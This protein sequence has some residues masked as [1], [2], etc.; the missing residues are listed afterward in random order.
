[1]HSVHHS[2]PH[3]RHNTY[4]LWLLTKPVRGDE[5]SLYVEN[6][7]KARCQSRTPIDAG[8]TLPYPS[9]PHWNRL[10]SDKSYSKSNQLKIDPD[11][12]DE[13]QVFMAMRAYVT[14]LNS[15]VVS[16]ALACKAL[17]AEVVGPDDFQALLDDMI[18]EDI[19]DL[20]YTAY[21]ARR[22]YSKAKKTRKLNSGSCD[23]IATAQDPAPKTIVE[24]LM[25]DGADEWVE[26]I[27]KEFNGLC[28]QGVF[29]HDW[30][31]AKLKKAGITGKPVP[32]S[33]ALVT[34]K[35]KDGVLEKWKT[36]ICIAGHRG[37]VT[38][39]IHYHEVFSPSPVQHTERLLQAMRAK[40][41]LHNLTW[42][43]KMAYTWAPLPAGER[44][45]VVY[46]DGF[47]RYDSQGDE[48][49]AVL[50]HYLY[51]MPS[52]GRGWGKH[53]DEFILS[54][55]NKTGW[56]CRR[57][58]MDPCLFVIDRDTSVEDPDS[59]PHAENPELTHVRE[60]GHLAPMESGLPDCIPSHI[61]RS[62][63]LIHTDDCDAYGE[64]MSILHDI[65]NIMNDKWTTEIIDA[66]FVLGVKRELSIDDEGLWSVKMSMSAFISDLYDV[67][68][69]DITSTLGRKI[70]KIPFPEGYILTKSDIPH[71]G[72]VKS[73]LLKQYQR[74]I[75]SL[76][77]YVRHISPIAAYGCSQLCKLMS[78]PT[79]RAYEAALHMLVYLYTHRDEGIVFHE[80]DSEPIAFVDASNKDD[81]TDGKTQYGYTIMWGGPLI[82]CKSSKL[83]H[84]GINSTYNEYMA[85]HHVIKQ[86]VW[87]R[88]LFHE[89]G[90]ANF[91]S[92]PTLVHA[93][94]KQA[95]S[96]CSEDL[97]TQGNMYFRTGYHY[98]K[99]AV[100]DLY[101]TIQYIDTALNISDAMTKALG[102]NKIKTFL[103]TLHGL[104][105]IP[106]S[107][108]T[109][110]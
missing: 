95:N 64:D 91:I 74:L 14:Q 69:D 41:H 90:L 58:L 23:T 36:R 106:D 65:N 103:D 37:N 73:T 1:M 86:I 82:L 35:Y 101:V 93:D 62:W 78:C 97:V 72:E 29:S 80:T 66:S 22:Y 60:R 105:S 6:L 31:T 85:L 4:R 63:V 77:W 100:R 9:G 24:A 42:D 10:C 61:I 20:G 68:D 16:M 7:P 79:E 59:L 27:Y 102:S 33:T 18:E 15:G 55:F 49:F 56:S 109:L 76:L 104:V 38:Q 96:L 110:V 17:I 84:V 75:G 48:L 70:P 44:I 12:L 108:L 26:S 92:M 51:G 47:K 34:H 107:L 28:D 46:P 81:P 13:E 2:L 25:G 45:A 57:S 8:L 19:E 67:Y 54:R 99:E 98:C 5:P 94:N 71:P 52:A 30:D 89:I 21:C 3:E 87:L 43:V 39:G 53:R 50:E 88:Q 32:C 83:N 40:L 11:E